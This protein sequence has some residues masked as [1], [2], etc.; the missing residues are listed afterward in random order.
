VLSTFKDRDSTISASKLFLY[1]PTHIVKKHKIKQNKKLIYKNIYIFISPEFSLLQAKKTLF[2]P[3]LLTHQVFQAPDYL[4]GLPLDPRLI[5]G[6][7]R[8]KVFQNVAIH[9]KNKQEINYL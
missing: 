7:Q 1:L 3:P 5:S 4:S 6:N 2:S 8:R 9:I